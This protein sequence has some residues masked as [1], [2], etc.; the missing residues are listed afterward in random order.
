MRLIKDYFP[1]QTSF[2]LIVPDENASRGSTAYYLQ[3][4]GGLDGLA[5]LYLEG[6]LLHLDGAA[7]TLLSSSHST[8]SSIR[9]PQRLQS[10]ENEGEQWKRD[11]EAAGRYFK[12]AKSLQP[13]LDVPLLTAENEGLF[14][15]IGD[16]EEL[17]MPSI[18]LHSSAP[19]SVDSRED[20][21]TDAGPPA[22]RRRRK[23]E[24]LV[25]IHNRERKV[26]V[27]NAWYLYIPG[28]VGAGTALLVVG[29]VGALSF[30]TWR[31]NQ[32]S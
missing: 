6:G 32:G 10:T 12:R 25:L 29:V 7:F 15:S 1:V 20:L 9:M 27:D 31:R 18:E 23:K 19:E 21:H 14:H 26:D 4:I 28:L 30:S 2:E 13:N 8:L 5:Q 24:E 17:E 3:C 11:R 22:M 16:S